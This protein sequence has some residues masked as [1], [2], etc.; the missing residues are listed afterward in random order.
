[1][2]KQLQIKY[3]PL[4]KVPIGDRRDLI[5]LYS[6]SV[7]PPGFNQADAQFVYVRVDEIWA[8]AETVKGWSQFSGINQIDAVTHKFTIPYYVIDKNKSVIEFEGKYY[9]IKEVINFEERHILTE[10]HCRLRG[11]KTIIAV[12]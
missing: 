9:N 10:L 2:P 6:R 4:K 3:K 1:V 11:D 5:I 7:T 8:K 12:E